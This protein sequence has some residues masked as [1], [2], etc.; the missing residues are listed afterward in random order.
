MEEKSVTFMDIC[1]VIKKNLI[2]VLVV[3][4]I[5]TIVGSLLV[6]FVYN[7]SK[8]EY[9]M[10]FDMSFLNSDS[11]QYPNGTTFNY[12]DCISL[13]S[14]NEIKKS[15]AEFGSI[16]VE[17]MVK[18]DGISLSAVTEEAKEKGTEGTYTI[19]MKAKY[20][21][22]KDQARDFVD[23]IMYYAIDKSNQIVASLNY[24]ANLT[25]YDSCQ[26]TFADK[27]SYL[28][29]QKAYLSSIYE[30]LIDQ[31][32][33]NYVVIDE[34]LGVYNGYTLKQLKLKLDSI[35]TSEEVTYWNN[36]LEYNRYKINGDLFKSNA[37]VQK[38]LLNKT[39]AENELRIAA[40]KAELQELINDVYAGT[41][42]D[43]QQD[44]AFLSQ[45]ESLTLQ[46]KNIDIEIADIDLTISKIDSVDQTS[47]N[48]FKDQLT[49]F[50]NS[51]VE[52]TTIT[53]MAN[54]A[55]YKEKGIVSASYNV[56]EDGGLNIILGVVISLLV[57]FIVI[58]IIVCIKDLP[59]Y[60]KEKNAVQEVAKVSE[61]STKVE[62][63]NE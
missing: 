25:A 46:N 52:A 22:D 33:E 41:T 12:K 45:I 5:I 53:R 40:L 14:L 57:G 58:A 35:M 7:K 49:S 9:S 56:T 51:L 37:A 18:E 10:N 3:T 8:T 54:I 31:V 19:T 38:A 44:N 29:A 24:S 27:L 30:K 61:E 13:S 26:T 39:K 62:E 1:H 16:D 23:E 20:F 34:S 36:Q 32:G 11:G 47:F 48:S 2:L 43:S 6:V 21:K 28:K 42:Y 60:L 63:A 15:N 50:D 55:V 17:K 4:A 59:K